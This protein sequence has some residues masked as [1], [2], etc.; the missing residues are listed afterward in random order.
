MGLVKKPTVFTTSS[1]CL[2]EEL[3]KKCDG[4][5]DHVPLMAGRAA[6]AQVYP[7]MLYEAICR[8]VVNSPEQAREIQQGH[9]GQTVVLGPQEL[10][11]TLCVIFKDQVRTRSST[12]CR[13]A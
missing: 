12:C 8:G 4:G 13:P 6:A 10:R 11:P 7:D 5:H 1:K 2:A 9:Y 3:N